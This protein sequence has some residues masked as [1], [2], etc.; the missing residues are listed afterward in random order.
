MLHVCLYVKNWGDFMQGLMI[1]FRQLGFLIQKEILTII[2][3]P[4]NRVILFAPALIQAILFGY[5]ATYDVNN[6]KYAVLDQSR[7][8]VSTEL[9]AR[10]D[11]SGHFH[12]VANLENS[13]QIA[14]QIDSQKALLVLVIPADFENKLNQQ[15]T[16]PIQLILDARNSSTAGIAS[17]YINTIVNGLNEDRAGTTASMTIETRSW[18]NPNLE[19]RWS[20]MPAL[21]AS[22][23]MIQT[24]LLSALSVAREREQSTFDQLL[25]TPL[26]PM[27][28]LIGKAIPSVIIGMIQSTIIMLIILFWFKIPMNG[29]F[30]LL[31]FGLFCFNIA[32]VGIGL[33]ISAISLNMQQAMQYT[34][35]IMMPLM[36]LS[37]LLTPVQNMPAFLEY[38]TYVNPLRFAIDLVRRVYLEGASFMQVA[39]NFVPMLILTCITLPLAAWLFR[40][41][42]S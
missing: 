17:S 26:N 10:L 7:G 6:A 25:V 19:S 2:K 32:T 34:F 16:S 12:R 31:Y 24:L 20:M 33:S 36:L 28:L 30:V 35:L 23:S 9:I 18:F 8:Q 29:S 22:L 3:E 13:S 38:A 37:G 1:W 14:E 15:Q 21:I 41:R 11:G 42:L 40:N 39:W 4:A 27:Q 5:A